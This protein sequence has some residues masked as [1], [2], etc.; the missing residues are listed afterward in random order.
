VADLTKANLTG[1]NLMQVRL[2]GARL[3]GVR[4]VDE[5][6][7]HEGFVPELAGCVMANARIGE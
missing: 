2:E 4:Y 7:W 1:A 3:T 5:T 6:K